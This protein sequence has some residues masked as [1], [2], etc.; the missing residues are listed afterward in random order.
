[1]DAIG[2]LEEQWSEMDPDWEYEQKQFYL[3]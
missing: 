3:R 1:M 2:P